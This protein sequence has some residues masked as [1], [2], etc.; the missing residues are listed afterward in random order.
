MAVG[1]SRDAAGDGV[2]TATSGS[3][4]LVVGGAHGSLA[5]ARSLGRQKIPVWFLTDDHPL[6]GYSRYVTRSLRWPGPLEPAAVDR[7]LR[8]AAQ[9]RLQGWTLF[10]G[11][12]AEVCLI[13]QHHAALSAVFQLT[14]PPWEVIRWS[15]DKRMTQALADRVGVASPWSC[16]P[17]SRDDVAGLDCRFP[18][19]VKPTVRERRNAL[20]QAKAWRADDRAELL[21]CYADAVALVGEPFVALQELIPGSGTHQFS[22][23]ALC[24]DGIPI[25]AVTARR[26]RQFP[27]EFGYTSTFVETIDQPEVEA[28]AGRVLQALKFDGLVEVEFKHD[29]RDGRYKLLDINARPWTWIGLGTIAGVDFPILAW[30]LARGETVTPVRGRPG[31]HWIH[32]TRDIAAVLLETIAGSASL[33]DFVTAFR[34][35][36]TFATFAADDPL[37]SLIEPPIVT[38]RVLSRWLPQVRQHLTHAQAPLPRMRH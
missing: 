33:R 2:E 35:P 37:P 25:A 9:H 11:G 14:T 10:A 13:G 26:T 17:R 22:Y 30:R 4:A 6:P 28:A 15:A 24:R 8:L 20:T 34:R 31:A 32:V 27:I 1:A 29:P 36:M 23:A 21:Q 38:A 7:L 16:Y 19:I 5:V 18:V 12:D 3:G